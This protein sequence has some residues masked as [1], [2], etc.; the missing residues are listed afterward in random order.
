MLDVQNIAAGYG[1]RPIVQGVNLEL[2]RGEIVTIIGQNGAGKSTL[3]KAI[4]AMAPQRSG[5]VRLGGKDVSALS[6]QA[7][8]HHGLA[9]IPQGRSLFPRLTVAEN[10]RMGGYLLDNS[11]LL[12]ER[13]AAQEARFPVLVG[14][15]GQFAASLSG[16]EQ[17][18][19]ELARTLVMEPDVL[20]L[21]EPSIG[22]APQVVGFLFTT[23]RKL[24][25]QGKAILMVEQNVRAA[26]EISDRGY[27]LELGSVKLADSAA[28]LLHDD[29]VAR[30]YMGVRA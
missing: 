6:T 9:Y 18:M 13:I 17:R 27:V 30:L 16:G 21:D 11:A 24:A 7:L 29:R 26:L 5:S 4:A 23:L 3:L 1:G 25:D 22:L 28:A 8:L 10:L 14:L 15:G 12:R 20:M 19:L 2:H